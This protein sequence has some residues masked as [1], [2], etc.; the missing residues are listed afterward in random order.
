[1]DY[2]RHLMNDIVPK[3]YH[4]MIWV[5]ECGHEFLL[6][7]YAEVFK[8]SEEVLRLHVFGPKSR[9]LLQKMGVIL[10]EWGLDEGLAIVEV[11]KATLLP[12]IEVGAF[13]RRPDTKGKWV[14]EL[15]KT[16]AHKIYRDLPLEEKRLNRG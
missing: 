2:E 11:D 7:K 14:Q 13:K 9:L 4:H 3:E 5:D 1:M 12:I 6:L 16:L 8:R 15:Q 10:N